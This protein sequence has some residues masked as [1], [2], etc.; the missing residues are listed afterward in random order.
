MVTRYKL[1][2]R[3]GHYITLIIQFICI[4]NFSEITAVQTTFEFDTSS[5]NLTAGSEDYE[6]IVEDIEAIVSISLYL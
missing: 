1:Q 2:E 5:V 4:F 3:I 6:N